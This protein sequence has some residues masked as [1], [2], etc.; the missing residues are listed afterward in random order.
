M[1][2]NY[3]SLFQGLPL[4]MAGHTHTMEFETIYMCAY[5][6]TH[7]VKFETVYITQAAVIQVVRL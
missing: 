2:P 7:R 4:L 3:M 1:F 5:T 6:H